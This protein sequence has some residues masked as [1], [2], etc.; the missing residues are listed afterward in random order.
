MDAVEVRELRS[1]LHLL[2]FSVGQAY[3]WADDDGTTLID[4]G[5]SGAGRLVARAL[6]DLGRQPQDVRRIVL[7]HFHEDHAGGA[8]EFAALSGA[9][10]LV[11][12]RDAPYVRGRAAGPEPVCEDWELPLRAAASKRLPPRPAR[13]VLPRHVVELTHGQRLG[14][15]GGARVVAAPGHTWGSIAV[16][17]PEHGVLFTGDAVAASPVDGTVMR[18]VFNLD[19]EAA[20]RSLCELA[21]LD[22][23]TACFGH[24]DPVLEDA[25]AA[26]RTAA[27]QARGRLRPPTRP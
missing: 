25:S 27:E 22:I 7:T 3:L 2:R 14:F 11:H 13:P 15:G 16:H 9:P 17:L 6:K 19:G 23:G 1:G 24:G 21:A 18:G 26:L 12:R 4:A 5:P 20:T 8:G 10:V